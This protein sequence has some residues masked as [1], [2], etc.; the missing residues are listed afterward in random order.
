MISYIYQ[1]H[2]IYQNLYAEAKYIFIEEAQFFKDLLL[3]I[4]DHVE[5]KGKNVIV[6]GL[7]GDS[8]RENFGDIHKLIPLCDEIVKL[9]EYCSI[10]KDGTPGIFSKRITNETSQVLIGSDNY[11]PCCRECYESWLQ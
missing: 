3:F 11:I 10:C 6:V 8:N 5:I 1:I 9:K 2:I 4:I 7:N